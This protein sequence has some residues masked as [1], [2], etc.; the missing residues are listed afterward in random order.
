MAS[1]LSL[2]FASAAAADEAMDDGWRREEPSSPQHNPFRT[3]QALSTPIT[4][5]SYKQDAI[6]P[7]PLSWQQR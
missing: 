6:I 7:A 2:A 3:T 1:D 4:K 5:D